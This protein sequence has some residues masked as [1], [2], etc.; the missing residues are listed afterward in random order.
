M[1]K[2]GLVSKKML[3]GEVIEKWPELTDVLMGDY[4]FHC[5]GCFASGME[6]LEDGARTHGMDDEEIK[7]MM[8]NL[9]ELVEAET[10]K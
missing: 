5:V 10:K 1:K 8:E 3:I 2:K 9:N 6:S 7:V 4:G